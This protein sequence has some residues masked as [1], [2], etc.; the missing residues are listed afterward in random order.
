MIPY[1]IVFPLLFVNIRPVFIFLPLIGLGVC[2]LWM[3]RPR[4]VGKGGVDWRTPLLLIF[5]MYLVAVGVLRGGFDGV[6]FGLNGGY[7]ALAPVVGVLVSLMVRAGLGSWVL[8]DD[9]LD[10]A[11]MPCAVVLALDVALRAV[12]LA[13]FDLD[14]LLFEFKY[15]GVFP[16]SNVAGYVASF[17]FVMAAWLRRPGWCC[18][19]GLFVLL[20]ASR[21]SMVALA[22]LAFYVL[23]VR[24]VVKLVL[25]VFGGL[26]AW[27]VLMLVDVN[28]SLESKFEILWSFSSVLSGMSFEEIVF[29]VAGGREAVWALIGVEAGDDF[30]SPHN[31]F[32]KIWLYFGLVSVVVLVALL[33]SGS[34]PIVLV[35][36]LHS[37]SGIMPFFPVCAFTLGGSKGA[38]YYASKG[39]RLSTPGVA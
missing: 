36:L 16:T 20:S 19:F 2:F 9:T 32:V 7:E 21:T 11:L 24:G 1:P 6:D 22:F 29:G 30:I 26:L 27:F 34:R 31:P 39:G 5:A 25:I 8:S 17:L 38:R 14:S 18:V 37:L 33:V 10:R 35:Y 15:G 12:G 13:A 4:I 28:W 23:P 3:V